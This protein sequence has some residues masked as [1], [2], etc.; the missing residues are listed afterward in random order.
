MKKFAVK[1]VLFTL[2]IVAIDRAF[3]LFK[4]K[5][6]NIFAEI[7]TN[8]LTRLRGYIDSNKV[9]EVDISVYGSSHPQFGISPEIINKETG[10]SCLNFA[11]GG[12]SNIGCQYEFIKKI[13]IKTKIMI[14]AIDITALNQKPA[15][16]DNFQ[17]AFFRGNNSI[18]DFSQNYLNYSNIYKY[19]HFVKN[20]VKN[21]RQKKYTLPYF[22]KK[23]KMDLS[24]FSQYNGYN[25]SP[26]GWVAANGYLN[27]N[28]VH[29]SKFT[30][31][32]QNESC[33]ALEQVVAYCRSNNAKLFI[34]QVPEHGAALRYKQKYIDMDKWMAKFAADNQVAYIN[35]DKEDVFPVNNDALFFDTDHLN[36]QGAELFSKQL[37]A[38]LLSL[39]N[40]K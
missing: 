31:K 8:K 16:I 2:F 19:S 17:Q 32:P 7:S 36:A 4:Y 39:N 27:P 15:K 6:K 12:G 23:E 1:I 20:Y 10:M 18:F 38:T 13:G 25:L 9:R 33:K 34:I 29:Y 37:S 11:Y 26:L 24:A 35:F 30:F 22:R 14:Y 3:I 28:H 5:T 40:V 21:I